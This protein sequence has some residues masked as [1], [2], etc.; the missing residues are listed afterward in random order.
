M[1]EQLS[2]R[3]AIENHDR[4]ARYIRH[5]LFSSKVTCKLNAEQND[6][7]YLFHTKFGYSLQEYDNTG[8][9]KEKM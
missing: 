4:D 9:P 5:M 3:C 1:V 7:T 8:D 2:P 6:L